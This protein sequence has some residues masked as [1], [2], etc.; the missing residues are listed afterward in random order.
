MKKQPKT[1]KNATKRN[2]LLQGNVPSGGA[3]THMAFKG[4]SDLDLYN[5]LV[6]G[7]FSAP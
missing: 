1:S 2:P 3:G 5:S 4:S 6:V 7:G